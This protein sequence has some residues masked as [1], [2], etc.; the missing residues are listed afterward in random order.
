MLRN[1]ADARRSSYF[2]LGLPV[3]QVNAFIHK[4]LILLSGC[5]RELKTKDKKATDSQWF[6]VIS[7]YK[8]IWIQIIL[9]QVDSVEVQTI[10]CCWLIKQLQ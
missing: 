4:V 8:D 6:L 7:I 2:K 5:L 3:D 10:L 9:I 1:N